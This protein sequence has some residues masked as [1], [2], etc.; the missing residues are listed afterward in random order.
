MSEARRAVDMAA[1]LGRRGVLLA[2]GVG[3]AAGLALVGAPRGPVAGEPPAGAGP[4]SHPAVLDRAA[5][6]GW[7]R[8]VVDGRT[9]AEPIGGA[10]WCVG[11][12]GGIW[13]IEGLDD[14]GACG[15]IGWSGHQRVVT[16]ESVDCAYGE[17]AR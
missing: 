16:D 8:R 14:A 17:G 15:E 7:C 6:T 1:R 2:V 11:R 10:W 4:R 12:P 5:L 3:I 9:T 13:R